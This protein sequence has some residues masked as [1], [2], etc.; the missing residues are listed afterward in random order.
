M[1]CAVQTLGPH[2]GSQ[3]QSVI[4][5]VSEGAGLPRTHGF[6]AGIG[7]RLQS[8]SLRQGLEEEAALIRTLLQTL[9]F[10]PRS[11]LHR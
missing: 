10:T 5:S 1:W 2:L 4:L 7:C 9:K 6:Q 3:W 8:R 11:H